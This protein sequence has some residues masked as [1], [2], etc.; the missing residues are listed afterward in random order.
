MNESC[1]EIKRLNSNV[2]FDSFFLREVYILDVLM[3]LLLSNC[4]ELFKNR[5]ES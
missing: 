4:S 5:D 3:C 1:D 2:P